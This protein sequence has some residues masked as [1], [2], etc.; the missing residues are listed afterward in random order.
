MSIEAIAETLG[1][2]AVSNFSRAFSKAI[3]TSPSK[4]RKNMSVLAET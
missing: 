1:Y 4:W 2:S 3:G